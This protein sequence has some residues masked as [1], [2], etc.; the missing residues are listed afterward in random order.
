MGKR[1]SFIDQVARFYGIFDADNANKDI[2]SICF[3]KHTLCAQNSMYV[4]QCN[5]HG[6]LMSRKASLRED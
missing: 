6:N 4:M 1:V 2:N 5:P 3:I